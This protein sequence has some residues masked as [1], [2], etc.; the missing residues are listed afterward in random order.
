MREEH[1]S[2]RD[3]L[4]RRG[5]TA[6]AVIV[7]V[8]VAAAPVRAEVKLPRVIGDHMVLQ[9][10]KPICIWGWAA[11]GEGVTVTLGSHRKT[12]Q[13]GKDGAWRV[14]LPAMKAGGP[15][16][17]TVAGQAN[18]L[19][20]KDILV[21][22]VWVCSGQSNME[23]RLV[24]SRGG[25]DAIRKANYPKIRLFH[26]PKHF[27]DKPAADVKTSWRVCSPKTVSWFSGVGF[28]FGRELHEELKVPIGLVMS[29][30]SGTRIEPWTPAAGV[31]SVGELAGKDKPVDGKLYNGMIHP[32]VP[33]AIRGVIWY[34]GEGNLDDGPIYYH[35]MRALIN[36]WRKVWGQGDFPFYY[37]QLAPLNWGPGARPG[38]ALPIIWEA[39]TAALAIPNTGMAM[40]NDIGNTGTAHPRN[41]LDVGKRLA[42]CAFAKTYGRKELVYSGPL[43]ESMK[44]EGG[45]VRITFKHTHAGLVSRDRKPLTR[46]TIAGADKKFVPAHAKIERGSV[47]VWSDA[48]KKPAAVR[49]GWHQIAEPNL[50]NKDGLPASSF[51]TDRW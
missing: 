8:C 43:Y 20:V 9:R 33:M 10:G 4:V 6:A 36:G 40:T 25:D 17:M 41:K 22:E 44:V 28:F 48:V 39:Q 37:V 46:F 49:F 5:M 11:P 51:H 47:V 16:V 27:S 2:V 19:T 26:V 13:T 29:A 15:H 34:P 35:R 3:G 21:G 42:L 24:A 38:T 7:L 14:E 45:R 1:G 18:K 12:V 32:F 23:W 31:R 50:M 30:V